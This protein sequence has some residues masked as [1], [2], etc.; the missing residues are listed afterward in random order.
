[1]S[2]AWG[3]LLLWGLFATGLLTVV[4]AT[5]QGMGW[6]RV[7]LPYI[8]GTILTPRRGLAMGLGMGMHLASGMAFA[9]LY[10]L[11]FEAWGEAGLV[12][13]ALLGLFHGS[14]MLTVVMQTLPAVHPRMVGRHAGPTPTRQLEPPGFL[15]LNYGHTTPLVSM[16]AH[17]VYGAALGAFYPVSG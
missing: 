4:L 16:L 15:A 10:A 14:F 17:V 6:T 2:V 5:S 12:R 7:S 1:V 8:L 3:P 11:V 13:G 9:V